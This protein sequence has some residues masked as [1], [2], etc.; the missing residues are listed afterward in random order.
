MLPLVKRPNES[1]TYTFAFTRFP[2]II[3][4]DSILPSTSI[5][6]QQISG[7]DELE[8]GSAS[9]VNVTDP[10]VTGTVYQ[11]AG[12]AALMSGGTDQQT[13]EMTCTITTVGGSVLTCGGTLQV[14]NPRTQ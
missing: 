1:R 3:N 8:I 7:D 13:Y 14:Y 9:I 12:I 6:I 2:E 11:N 4:G 10:P 5:N